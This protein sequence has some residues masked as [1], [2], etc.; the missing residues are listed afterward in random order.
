MQQF[1]VQ[2]VSPVDRENAPCL[3]FL[4]WKKEKLDP[5]VQD[6]MQSAYETSTVQI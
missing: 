4:C 6:S 3:I 2:F 1:Q 5:D